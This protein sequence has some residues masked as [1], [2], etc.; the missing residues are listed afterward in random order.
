MALFSRTEGPSCCV[1]N[2]DDA[3]GKW[4]MISASSTTRVVYMVTATRWRGSLSIGRMHGC[5]VYES[6]AGMSSTYWRLV[7][8]GRIQYSCR[9]A[10]QGHEGRQ[11]RVLIYIFGTHV[12]LVM[13]QAWRSVLTMY[14]SPYPYPYSLYIHI[15]IHI[16]VH[17]S[18]VCLRGQLASRTGQWGDPGR[19]CHSTSSPE[20]L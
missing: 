9:K 6:D 15:H 19:L 18:V 14:S 11:P 17:T 16:H 7:R 8:H 10:I 20:W 3:S 13:C 1:V 5:R 12:R 2:S 4:H